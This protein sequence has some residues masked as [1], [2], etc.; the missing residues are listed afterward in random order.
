M[1]ME[2]VWLQLREEAK[3]II[4]KE[5]VLEPLL[6]DVILSKQS[7]CDALSQRLTRK[8]DYN[9]NP[10]PFLVDLFKE[11]LSGNEF[12]LAKCVPIFWQLT[13]VTLLVRI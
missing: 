6:N 12:I 5:P 11:A 7:L 10:K 8:L 13:T 3:V 4:G 9:H 1:L 2:H